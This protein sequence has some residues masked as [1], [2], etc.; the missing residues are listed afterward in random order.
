MSREL[1]GPTAVALDCKEFRAVLTI[2]FCPLTRL[3]RYSDKTFLSIYT[4]IPQQIKTA[5]LK[6]L[7]AD[8]SQG[9]LAIIFC[10]S[11]CYPKVYR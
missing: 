3:L 5:F 8:L 4:Y 7:R 2:H 9:M 11:V 10:F 6:K 1:S